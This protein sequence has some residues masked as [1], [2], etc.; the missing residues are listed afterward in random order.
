MNLRV[1]FHVQHLLGIGHAK[2]A[3][4]LARAM[5]ARGLGVTVL[6]GGEPVAVEWG[7]AEII[8]LPWARAVDASF[9]TLVDESGRP[10][11]DAFHDRRRALVA[12]AFRRIVPQVV[13]LESYPFGRRA[14]R[15]E[16]DAL[17]AEARGRR[18]RAAVLVS[19]RDIL[20]AKPNPARVQEIV[21][22]VREDV[23]T[24][25]VHGDPSLIPLGAS[26]PAAREIA[27]KV[28]YTGYVTE[29]GALLGD[30]EPISPSGPGTNEVVVSV[31]GGAVGAPLL[32]AALAARPQTSAAGL[33][34]RLI[35]GPNLPKPEYEA[36]ARNLPAGVVLERFRY[37]F[38]AVLRRC[39]LSLSQAGYNT[40]LDVLQAGARAVVVPFA[41]AGE[42]EQALRARILAE[43]GLIQMVDAAVLGGPD[44][45]PALA[46]AIERALAA[47]PATLGPLALDG[48]RRS[49]DRIAEVAAGVDIR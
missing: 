10:L 18:P 39:H 29:R 25:L 5:T 43:R 13:L 19:I 12:N 40:I 31:G 6:A 17:V 24:V 1:L 44:G 38:G 16:L 4:A 3:A 28:L 27:E 7:G 2:R 9:K 45:I 41:E 11:D 20:V 32:R 37:D 33:R 47:P 36:L 46:A 21:A 42:T 15:R 23:D 8:Q 34:W 14:F 49:A 26:F 22:R 30:L 35:A 48:A